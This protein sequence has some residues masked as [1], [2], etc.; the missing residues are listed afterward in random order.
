MATIRRW[1]AG[2]GS[3]CRTWLIKAA[4][5]RPERPAGDTAGGRR[6]A[7]GTTGDL[8][9]TVR[10]VAGSQPVLA[11]RGDSSPNREQRP[12]L[13]QGSS[14]GLAFGL[15][16]TAGPFFPDLLASG[17]FRVPNWLRYRRSETETSNGRLL[18]IAPAAPFDCW[19]GSAAVLRA[20]TIGD[21]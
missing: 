19:P 5:G 16:L 21:P 3:R 7:G 2:C 1:D 20:E 4:G 8:A 6:L 18:V 14:Y 12:G 17:R 13:Y 11:G 15:G 9:D 10:T